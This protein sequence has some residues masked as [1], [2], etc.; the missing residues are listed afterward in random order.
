MIN[1]LL[2]THGELGKELLK[3]SELIIG[4]VENAKS[5]SFNYGDSFDTLLKKVE[6]NIEELSDDELIVFTDMYGG[7]P[8]NAVNRAMKNRDF[9]HITGINF[10]LFID[11]A[12]SRDSYSLKD[13]AEKIIKNGKKSIVFVNEKFLSD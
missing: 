3:S 5:I 12:I 7:S 9:Y 10:P 4:E 11:I 6:E 1:I 2:V 8:Y 13:I